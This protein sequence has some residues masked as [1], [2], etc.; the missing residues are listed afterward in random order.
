MLS[1]GKHQLHRL[2]AM[3]VLY[4]VAFSSAGYA[5]QQ[6]R[7]ES[8]DE[9][10][11][12][13]TELVQTEV[14]VLDGS[15]DFVEGLKPEQFQLTFNGTPRSLSFFDEVSAGSTREVAQVSAA[16]NKTKSEGRT[17]VS[18]AV[19]S[20]DRGRMLFFF[21]DDVHLSPSSLA[22]ARVA[23]QK[24]VDEQMNAN[25]QVAIVSTSGQI[26]FLQQLTDNPAVLRAA[27]A[28]LSSKIN[29]ETYTGRTQ[30]SEYMAS[31]VLDSGNRELYA[32]LLES[33]KLEMQSGPGSRHGD[34]RLAA[35]YSSAPYLRNRLHTVNNIARMSAEATLA[36]LES[37]MLSSAVL[38][39][40]KVVFFLSDGFTVNE[41]KSGALETLKRITREAAQSGVVVYTMDARGTVFNLGSSVDAS[42]NDYIDLS[43]RRSGMSF[44]EISAMREALKIIADDTGGRAIFDSNSIE[45]GVR[46]AIDE[47]SKYYLLAWRPDSAADWGRKHDLR[48]SIKGH[49]NFTVRWRSNYAPLETIAQSNAKQKTDS[50][51]T[52]DN[53]LHKAAGSLYAQKALP[54]SLAAGYVNAVN[55]EQLLKISMQIERQLLNLNPEVGI[56]KTEVDVIGFAIDESEHFS[57]FKQVVTVG[58]KPSQEEQTVTWNQQ[59]AVKPGLYQVRVAARERSSGRMGSA[60]QWIEVPDAAG[61]F[62][63]SS[64]FL[65]ER[66]NNHA[67][68]NSGPSGPVA[69]TVD[70]NHRFAR[71]SVLRFQTYVYNA[72]SVGS[73]ADVWIQAHV[74]SNRRQVMSVAA[75]RVPNNDDN[76]RLPYWSEIPLNGLPAGQYILVVTATDRVKDRSTS[77]RMK[78]S[79][80]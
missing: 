41:R 31:Q 14:T 12:I 10:I 50:P 29:P 24:F 61:N 5:Q 18:D 43:A 78:F 62:A 80:E 56:D 73:G 6:G 33:T 47:T 60:M 23:L 35:S 32:Y 76:V 66:K 15:G 69:I 44:G 74:M 37:L 46:Q 42:T 68:A 36:A 4:I 70:V 9:V 77:Q 75:A 8:Q 39:G 79:V 11:R 21:L 1:F 48:V 22:R 51:A 17:P 16:Q 67:A 30:I 55:G 3:L 63:L 7:P 2:I 40:R 57:S 64:L 58:P 49:P 65:A 34:H 71:S 27:I 59:V 13:K 45:D 72:G 28:R 19:G 54:V 26:G 25:D 53:D 38:P 52:V 20:S